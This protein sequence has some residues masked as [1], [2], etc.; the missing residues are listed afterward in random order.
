V[1]APELESIRELLPEGEAG[2]SVGA[3]GETAHRTGV[4]DL[5]VRLGPF[6]VNEAPVTLAPRAAGG[7]MA[8]NVGNKFLRAAGIRL[9]LDYSGRR[10]GFYGEC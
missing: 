2:T 7:S 3:R 9:L 4:L 1:D 10:V 8:V 6:T 5:P